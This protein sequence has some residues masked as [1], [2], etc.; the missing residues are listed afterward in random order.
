MEKTTYTRGDND[1]DKANTSI[2]LNRSNDDKLIK[3]S[4]AGIKSTTSLNCHD[5]TT[6]QPLCHT[7][8]YDTNHSLTIRDALSSSAKVKRLL[9]TERITIAQNFFVIWLDPSIDQTNEDCKRSLTELQR[10]VHTIKTFTNPDECVDFIRGIKDENIFMIASET[11]GFNYVPRVHQMSQIDSIYIFCGNRSEH[12]QWVEDWE[13]IKGVFTDIRSLCEVLHEDV[14][15]CDRDSTPI[16][17]TNARNP[18]EL[19]PTFMYT[20]LFKETILE[21]E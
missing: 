12:E 6:E 15:V 4:L 21:I 8:Q 7:F 11:L 20:T 10:I 19:D 3:P 18:D 17:M 2:A 16:T 1:A 9:P 5:T 13:K 14:R